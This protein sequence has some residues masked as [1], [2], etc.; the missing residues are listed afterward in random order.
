MSNGNAANH[1][2]A[3][4]E[5][6]LRKRIAELEAALSQSNYERNRAVY[7][8]AELRRELTAENARLR[9]AAQEVVDARDA[10]G[11]SDPQEHMGAYYKFVAADIKA[12]QK[13]KA[14]LGGGE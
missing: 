8:E 6:K 5:E 9:D 10:L 7:D 12:H 14:L 2:R 11:R 4:E 1:W 3:I 13:L